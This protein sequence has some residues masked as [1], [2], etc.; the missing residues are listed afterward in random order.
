MRVAR[1]V[2][3]VVASLV[4]ALAVVGTATAADDPGM[5]HNIIVPGMTHN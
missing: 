1:M 2:V 5:T 3:A 4:V